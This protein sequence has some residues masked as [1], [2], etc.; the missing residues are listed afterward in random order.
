MVHPCERR[1]D[2]DR[3]T[4]FIPAV[5][6]MAREDANLL[7]RDEKLKGPPVLPRGMSRDHLHDRNRDRTLFDPANPGLETYI[8][9]TRR[10]HPTVAEEVAAQKAAQ[11]QHSM[12]Q[13]RLACEAAD[14]NELL[15]LR[16]LGIRTVMRERAKAGPYG[17]AAVKVPPADPRAD[18]LEKRLMGTDKTL[19]ESMYCVIQNQIPL[20]SASGTRHRLHSSCLHY[21]HRTHGQDIRRERRIISRKFPAQTNRTASTCISA[22]FNDAAGSGPRS[23]IR[24]W[25]A[26]EG[27]MARQLA[28]DGSEVGLICIPVRNQIIGCEEPLLG[29]VARPLRG[30]DSGVAFQ[31]EE[32]SFVWHICCEDKRCVVVT[33]GVVGAF[34]IRDSRALHRVVA[35][36]SRA[37]D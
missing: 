25:S 12:Q 9:V 28:Q 17:H 24:S 22:G 8:R 5:D 7:S 18:V 19:E 33:D 21:F 27:R 4:E 34:D 23:L 15:E 20:L 16:S 26:A 3:V 11:D 29:P 31:R 14:A 36:A 32:H 2:G 30:P 6:W 35:V 10:K 37:L 1:V 13:H